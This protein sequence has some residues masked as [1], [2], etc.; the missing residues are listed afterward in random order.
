MELSEN[1]FGPHL[2]I[3]K[4][5]FGRKVAQLN[6]KLCH[7]G[8]SFKEKPNAWNSK[9]GVF[10]FDLSAFHFAAGLTESISPGMG[11]IE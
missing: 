1:F 11:D 3:Y 9:P 6:F 8:C 5:D 4:L 7:Y 2:A 10:V